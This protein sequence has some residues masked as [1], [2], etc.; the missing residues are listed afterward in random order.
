[1]M[2]DFLNKHGQLV[3]LVILLLAAA[4]WFVFLRS[5]SGPNTSKAFFI[6]DDTGEEQVLSL[7]EYPPRVNPRTGKSTLVQEVKYTCDGGK[8]VRVAYLVKYTDGL[9][10]RLEKAF[11]EQGKPAGVDVSGGTWVRSPDKNA[12]WVPAGSQ[13]GTTVQHISCPD[14]GNIEV[15]MPP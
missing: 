15:V 2:R 8:T 1:M 6:D 7:A 3:A 13:D 14:G 4:V 9:K 10:Q 12:K 5:P 11:K